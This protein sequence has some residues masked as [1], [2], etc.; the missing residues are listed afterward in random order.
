MNEDNALAGVIGELRAEITAGRPGDRLPSVRELMGRH[1]VSPVT[2]QRAIRVLVAEGLVESVP[3]KG[4]FVARPPAPPAAPDLSWQAVALGDQPRGEEALPELLAVPRA[5]AIPLSSGYLDAALQPVG[6]LGAA[7]ARAARNPTSWERGPVE[8]RDALRTWFAAEAGGALRA[9][10][11]VVCPGGQPALTTAFRALAKPGDPVLVEA[12]TYLGAIAAARHA[13]LRV[14][15]VPSDAHGVRPDLLRSAFDRTGA[16]LF[17]SQPLYANPHGAVLS[18]E[19][20]PQVLDAVREAGAFLLEDDWA[21]DLTIDPNPP[22]PLAADDTDGHVVY[23]RSLTKSAAPG[24]RVAAVGAR[25]VAGARLRTARVLDDFFVAGPLQAAALDFVTSPAW[26]RHRRKL[27]SALKERRDALLD[28]LRRRLPTVEPAMVPQGGL[29]VWARLPDGVDDTAL[30][31]A[32]A[33]RSVIVF[34]G[35]P[36][37]AAE[38]PAAHLRLTYGAAAPEVLDEGVRRLAEALTT[39]TP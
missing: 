35:R 21:R 20:R 39:V 38:S 15:P 13:G 30:T 6:P 5:E 18:A 29:H 8:G 3:G 26:Q 10:D 23:L 1:H 14:V 12:P 2:V 25:G 36:W 37:Y 27:Q 24:L 34:P 4:S 9:G 33:A 31:A 11:M 32:A 16:R 28:S 19:R 7:L 17:Y 22:R